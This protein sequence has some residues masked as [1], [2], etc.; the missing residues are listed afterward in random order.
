MFIYELLLED[1]GNLAQLNV[2]PMID[3]LKQQHYGAN[4]AGQRGRGPTI[5][6]I[7][8]KFQQYQPI[9]GTTSEV[10]DFIPLKDGFKSL[11]DAFKKATNDEK[12]PKGFALYVDKKAVAFA[13]T[14]YEQLRGGSRI[15]KLAYD[16]TPFEA[17]IRRKEDEAHAARSKYYRDPAEPNREKL[18]TD[19]EEMPYFYKDYNKSDEENDAAKAKLKP[20]L[21]R[22]DVVTTDSINN[23]LQKV[24]EYAAEMGGKLSIKLVYGDKQSIL[25]AR[26]RQYNRP[27]DRFDKPE[28]YDSETK[29]F[30][31]L[32]RR[33]AIYKNQKKPTVDSIEKFIAVSL[34]HPGKTVRFDGLTYKLTASTYDQINPIL[35]LRGATFTTRYAAV[36]PD[37]GFS[38]TLTL[39]YRF[40]Q[41]SNQL[42]P[43]KAEW[44]ER[45]ANG[46]KTHKTAV[47]DPVGYTKSELNIKT[48]SKEAVIKGL[49]GK[50]RD[51]QFA[52]A[53]GLAQGIV[54]MGMDWPELATIEKSAQHELDKAK[55]K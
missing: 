55:K 50:M 38:T 29:A 46:I 23:I 24:Q 40:D 8:N 51:H 48:M 39:T 45:D 28:G 25:K 32:K 21:Y 19:K 9:I 7:A 1:L 4:G 17:I 15:S 12:D 42:I 44:Y 18:K 52:S 13:V 49:L 41:E 31:D 34:S 22:G 3:I 35:L 54:K 6:S 27:M 37:A 20:K 36:D 2:G 11:R 47:L 26:N 14:D 30:K 43:I 33:L 16:F 53:L 5:S 10:S